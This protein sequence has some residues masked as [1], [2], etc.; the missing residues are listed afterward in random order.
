MQL[1]MLDRIADEIEELVI[2]VEA[3]LSEGGFRRVRRSTLVHLL[4]IVP[5]LTGSIAAVQGAAG[6]L[7]TAG[8]IEVN[9]LAY[10][11]FAHTELRLDNRRLAVPWDQRLLVE[12]FSPRHDG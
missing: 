6:T 4:K 7:E 12:A 11:A 2:E 3:Y 10:L 8:R 9:P 5:G 1:R